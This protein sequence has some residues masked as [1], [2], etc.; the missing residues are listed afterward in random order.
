MQVS[1]VRCV[2][3]TILVCV[4]GLCGCFPSHSQLDEEK[5]SHFLAG[6]ARANAMDYQG[7][8]ECFEKAIETNPRSAAAHFEAGLICEKYKP[9]HAAAIYHFNKF[10][11]L[12]P[13]SPYAQVVN[14][15]ILACKQ[16]LARSVSLTPITQSLQKEF[17]QLSEEN[18]RL[19]QEVEAWRAK[20]RSLSST[21]SSTSATPPSVA[22][23]QLSAEIPP[24][25][26]AG[27]SN[28]SS[29]ARS[30]LQSGRTHTVK[31]GDTPAGIARKYGIRVDMLLGANPK[32]DPRRLHVGQSVIVPT[33]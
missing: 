1:S 31:S 22:S 30:M 29:T 23:S 24:S 26:T 9:D 7:G 4:L 6:K 3:S 21:G 27:F 17:E 12:R 2:L 18:R 10:L 16:E 8:L 28:S 14:Q 5:E 32:L 33:Q 15:H 20:A 13:G 11:E 19:R 25:R